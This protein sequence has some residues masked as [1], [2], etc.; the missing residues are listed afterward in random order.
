MLATS[1]SSRTWP[2][3]LSVILNSRGRLK[4]SCVYTILRLAQSAHRAANDSD[5]VGINTP[6][7]REL[8]LGSRPG[9]FIIATTQ[10]CREPFFSLIMDDMPLVS[11]SIEKADQL[12]VE[13]ADS[14]NSNIRYAAYASRLQTAVRA[15]HRYIAYVRHL[16]FVSRLSAD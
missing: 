9:R 16:Q 15:G 10:A 12:A 2:T 13:G 4:Q 3:A 11:S 6:E 5:V 14:T 1:R 8:R 7:S